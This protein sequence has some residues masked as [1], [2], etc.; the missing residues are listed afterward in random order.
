[1][2]DGENST[3]WFVLDAFPPNADDTEPELFASP[4]DER[5]ETIRRCGGCGTEIPRSSEFDRGVRRVCFT[6]FAMARRGTM[7]L[8][9]A[10]SL[11]LSI[12]KEAGVTAP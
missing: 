8:G 1:M 9:Q 11:I 7:T 6:I 10:N 3:P 2:Q 12:C 5:A 4:I